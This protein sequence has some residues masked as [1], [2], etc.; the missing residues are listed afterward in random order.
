MIID[1]LQNAS[2]YQTLHPRFAKAFQYIQAHDW[3]KSENETIEIEDGLKL[4]VSHKSGK[5]T[6]ESL[7]KFE[8]HNQHID[9]Q[10]CISGEERIGWKPREKCK[11]PKGVYNAEKDVLFFDEQ[12]DTFFNLTERQFVIFFPEDVHAPMIGNGMI[13]K[14]VFK[15]K[16]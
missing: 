3:E 15:V 6:D 2:K 1:S 9:I 7:E 10:Y 16:I 8:C 13:K 4:M 5:T 12:P 11:H 14:L